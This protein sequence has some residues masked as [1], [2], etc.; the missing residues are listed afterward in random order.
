M[1]PRPVLSAYASRSTPLCFIAVCHC[2]S[3]CFH[4]WLTPLCLSLC[5]LLCVQVVSGIKAGLSLQQQ[6]DSFMEAA[7][8]CRQ[9]GVN[10]RLRKVLKEQLHRWVAVHSTHLAMRCIQCVCHLPGP[11]LEFNSG[12]CFGESEVLS[13]SC[14]ATE[15]CLGRHSSTTRCHTVSCC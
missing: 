3:P 6:M 1:A 14:C 4:S 9:G 8:A 10:G 2:L 15:A 11:Q 5:L 7:A 12:A 13:S